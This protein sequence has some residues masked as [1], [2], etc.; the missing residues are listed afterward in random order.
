MAKTSWD[1]AVVPTINGKTTAKLHGDTFAIT[2]Q[3]K[4]QKVAFKVLSA[5]VVDKDLY[6]IYGGMP[7]KVEDRPEFFA[8]FDKRAAPNKVDWSVAT[9][10][11]KYPDLPNHEAWLPNIAKANGLF[12]KF[13]TNMD[14]TPGLDL[15]KEITK[16]QADLDALFKSAPAQ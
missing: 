11:L 3:S 16:L 2:K 6:Q 14:Q 13:R 1:I 12:D 8:A 7:A 5:M 9:E 10:M 15:D 4:Q